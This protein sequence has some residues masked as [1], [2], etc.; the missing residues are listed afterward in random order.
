M[1]KTI[2]TIVIAL[3][4]AVTINAQTNA[5]K[6]QTQV[7]QANGN[8]GSS[9]ELIAEGERLN[10]QVIS[11]FNEGKFDEALPLAMRLSEVW[12]TAYGPDNKYVAASLVYLGELYLAKKDIKKAEQMYSQ[13]IEMSDK[14]LQPNEL[15]VVKALE[16]YTCI[17][18]Q[19]GQR[20]KVIGFEERRNRARTTSTESG[21]FWGQMS[22]RTISMPKPEKKLGATGLVLIRV[23]VDEQGKV[24]GAS[25]MCGSNSILV[26]ASKAAAMNARFNPLMLSGKP[27]KAIGYLSYDFIK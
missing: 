24:I 26:E 13:V 19:T 15:K 3:L 27:V 4:F 25:D 18:Y 12:R 5:D 10:A 23:V 6:N 2:L 17:L 21:Q 1:M 22:R 7:E 9:S 8:K 14:V 20:D 16:R 11:L